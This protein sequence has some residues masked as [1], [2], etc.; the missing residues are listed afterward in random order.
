MP[1][2]RQAVAHVG[3]GQRQ[4]RGQQPHVEERVGGAQLPAARARRRGRP[5]CPGRSSRGAAA[6]SRKTSRAVIAPPKPT[7]PGEVDARERPRAAERPRIGSGS[8]AIHS[9]A[10]TNATTVIGT[11]IEERGP[12][13]E[14][15]DQ[16]PA[17]RRADRH[18]RGAGDGQAAQDLARR[19]LQA[20]GGG[21]PADQQHRRRVAGRGTES[22]KH[23][24]H[25]QGRQVLARRRRRCRRPARWRCRR[26][27]P[28]AA[29][30]PRPAG[31][32]WA[33]R[34]RWSGRGS[35]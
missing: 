16:Q 4:V 29:R 8:F 34:S 15:A 22:D 10:I 6:T 35:R 28:A 30:T 27:I 18:G 13:V 25:D 1:S 32:R 17:D 9:S 2:R 26:G 11:L 5:R 14:P 19:G 3:A 20:D 7:T 24:R 12:P 21:S 23:A 31:R 33:G